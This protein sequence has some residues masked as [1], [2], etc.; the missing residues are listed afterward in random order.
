MSHK[1]QQ[2][3]DKYYNMD[4]TWKHYCG[5]WNKP[6]IEGQIPYDSTCMKYLE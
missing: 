1:N 5:K 2:N 3:A 6:D 4:K